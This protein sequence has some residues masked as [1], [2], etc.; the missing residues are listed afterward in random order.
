MCQEQDSPSSEPGRGL[1]RW[2]GMAGTSQ[3]EPSE[4]S[5]LLSVPQRHCGLI[6]CEK[7]RAEGDSAAF[8]FAFDWASFVACWSLCWAGVLLGGRGLYALGSGGGD[9]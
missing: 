2:G 9:N 7:E 8:G 4:L 5:A 3:D 1:C 6:E